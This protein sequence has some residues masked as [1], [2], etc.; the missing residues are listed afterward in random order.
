MPLL[1]A[2]DTSPSPVAVIVFS[3][4]VPVDPVPV[5]EPPVDGG[6]AVFSVILTG[7]ERSIVDASSCTFLTG[8]SLNTTVVV[9]GFNARK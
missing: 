4:P 7:F 5:P 9:P 3:V 1:S 2:K 6:V 8:K